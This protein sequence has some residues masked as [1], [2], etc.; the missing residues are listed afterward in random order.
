MTWDVYAMR[1]PGVRRLEDLSDSFAPR[2]L[3]QADTIV[4]AIREAA[5]H[6]DATDPSWLLLKGPDHDVEISLGKAAQVHS[7]TFY[8][9][10]GDGAVPLVLDLCRRLAI[11]PFDTESGD[12]LTS[13]SQPPS[14][15]PPDEDD[16]AGGKRK[17]WR[18]GGS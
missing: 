12:V 3:G 4:A 17:W 11:T 10:G 15:P 6:V 13:G 18:R 7:L 8:I 16:D 1:A 5:P 9:A 2:I 14:P